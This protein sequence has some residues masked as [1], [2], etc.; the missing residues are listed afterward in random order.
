MSAPDSGPEGERLQKVLAAAGVA[1]RRVVEEMIVARRIRVN[2][3]VAD[4]LGR[5]IDPATD[6]IEVD[7][8]AV[9]LDTSRR[10]VMLNKP[11][12]VVS[13]LAD[14]NGR[15]D[16]SLYTKNFQ[17]RLF[18][19]GRLDAETSGLLVLTNDGE[20]AHVLAH[21]SFGVTKTYIAKVHGQVLAQTIATLT[22]GIELDDGPVVADKARL[23]GR[24]EGRSNASLVEITLHSGRNR[25][26]RR[27]LAAVGH[28][29]IELV[30]RQFGPLHLGTLRS[31][32]LRDLTRDE[33]GALLTI[34]RQGGEAVA[35]APALPTKKASMGA[36]RPRP[37]AGRS[38]DRSGDRGG[39]STGG[40]SG[41]AP[42]RRSG[43]DK[44]RRTDR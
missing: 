31:G 17:E 23:L 42:P 35:A 11:V 40:R 1:S 9:Q 8:V 16:L 27:M 12:G 34:A 3:E 44:Q 33:L 10:Y 25:I 22:S 21:P 39:S 13:S 24:P 18:N 4:E 26:V 14:E 15:T 7:G 30:R 38:G 32:D 28:P 36:R 37:E 29:V 19:V 41:E 5:R 43:A 2:G 6:R 20:L